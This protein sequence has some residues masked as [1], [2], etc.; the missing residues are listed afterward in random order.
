MWALSPPQVYVD[1]ANFMSIR[2]PADIIYV[3][4]MGNAVRATAAHK[5]VH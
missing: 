3:M 4:E 1:G 2:S 5:W